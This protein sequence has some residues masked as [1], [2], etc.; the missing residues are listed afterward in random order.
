[1]ST[2]AAL[3]DRELWDCLTEADARRADTSLPLGV[4]IRS[5]ETYSLC[6]R[7]LTDRGHDYATLKAAPP[8]GT[9]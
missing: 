1:M 3:T 2:K 6:L 9:P 8:G 7:A 5:C 4:R